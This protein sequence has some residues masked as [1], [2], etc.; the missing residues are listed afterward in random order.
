LRRRPF[1]EHRPYD[2][3]LCEWYSFVLGARHVGSSSEHGMIG[4][5]DYGITP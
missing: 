1:F 4:A 5:A 3:F 2:A